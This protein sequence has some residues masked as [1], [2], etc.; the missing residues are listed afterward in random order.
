MIVS[1]T[2][3]LI[4]LDHTLVPYFSHHIVMTFGWIYQIVIYQ[5]VK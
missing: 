1:N 2:L 3:N 4:M 5:I